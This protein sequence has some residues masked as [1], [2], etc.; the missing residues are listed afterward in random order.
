M[1][2]RRRSVRQ[3]PQ[4]DRPLAERLVH[5]GCDIHPGLPRSHTARRHHEYLRRNDLRPELKPVDRFGH[6]SQSL[7]LLARPEEQCLTRA[8]GRAHRLLA[9]ARSVVA[10]VALHH[11]LPVF[12]QFRH[13][14]RTC[15]DAVAAGDAPRLAR[16]LYDAVRCP[17]DRI[18][19]THLGACRLLAVHADDGTVC[20]VRSRSM[21]SR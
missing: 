5:R 18:G 13:A 10:H 20:T 11:D 12:I 21:Y 9:N 2:R 14:E 8:Y 4:H 7:N 17:L 15:D 16:R 3:H 1:R 19:R 6:R